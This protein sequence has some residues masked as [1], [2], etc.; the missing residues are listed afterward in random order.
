MVRPFTV[1]ITL[2]WLNILLPLNPL[3]ASSLLT[4]FEEALTGDFDADGLQDRLEIGGE[5]ELVL[6]RGTRDGEFLPGIRRRFF[7]TI[8]A[9]AVGEFDRR[10]GLAD[11]VVGLESPPSLVLLQSG[12]GAWTTSGETVALGEV[13][14]HLALGGFD[15]LGPRD[16]AVAS[17]NTLVL[18]HGVDPTVGQ[19]KRI[20][21]ETEVDYAITH[22]SNGR[23]SGGS[24]R[25]LAVK[26]PGALFHLNLEDRSIAEAWATKTGVEQRTTAEMGAPTFV[27]DSAADVGDLTPGDGLCE[28]S[29]GGPCTLRA[30]V[31]EADTT[32]ATLD[33]IGF[34]IGGAPI[35][36]GSKLHVMTPVII[37]GFTEP[38]VTLL[39]P[40][41][42]P[43]CELKFF[44]GSSGLKGVALLV[45]CVEMIG[46]GNTFVGNKVGVDHTF[47][48]IDGSSVTFKGADNVIGGA[49]EAERNI[50]V[51]AH[52][53]VGTGA[54]GTAV[55][56]NVVKGNFFGV[57]P[58]GLTRIGDSSCLFMSGPDNT[59]G[60]AILGEGN[61]FAGPLA[62]FGCSATIFLHGLASTGNLI[63]GNALG[64]GIDGSSVLGGEVTGILGEFDARA[65][66]IGGSG[67]GSGNRIAGLAGTESHGI[68]LAGTGTGNHVKGN[69]IGTDL[70]GTFDLGVTG[71]G[72]F[73]EEVFSSMIG[74]TETGAGN[75]I[76]GNAGNG[77]HVKA[78]SLDPSLHSILGN[79][80]GVNL[81]GTIALANTGY[82]IYLE[83]ADEIT[84][85]GT[86]SGSG[87]LI[88]G[89]S[90][91]GIYLDT[92]KDELIQGN[93]IGTNADE[94]GLIPN[95][96]WGIEVESGRFNTIGGTDPGAG[97]TIAG[98]TLG[99]IG[100]WNI[101]AFAW[102]I[103]MSANSIY[104]NG[105]LA[106]DLDIDGVTANDPGDGDSVGANH[107][108]NFPDL[109]SVV[110]GATPT[111]SG[112]LSSIAS[113]SFEVQFFASSV[114][115][116]S[117]YGEGERYLG[118]ATVVTESD[119]LGTFDT[120][121]TESIA[122]G[123]FI[124]ATATDG[125]K[126]TSELSACAETVDA[127]AIFSDGFESGDVS[128]WSD[129]SN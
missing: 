95:G 125:E 78:H 81:G 10:D 49:T 112:T 19:E 77:I 88:S 98:N 5:Q 116:S 67:P 46:D 108:Q 92:V 26:S 20:M 56:H 110:P 85:G 48:D 100:V 22:L 25:L 11:I 120:V 27:V 38:G 97:N 84:I 36:L 117:G 114:C 33:T 40:S 76:S 15:G 74:G 101:G 123:E 61:L 60:G 45:P 89:N 4:N 106:I 107:G 14:R 50:F 93:F 52:L 43:F 80:I 6:Y 12:E 129:S 59:V 83:D 24:S 57:L 79:R 39:S 47:T 17:E 65:N 53:T 94:T 111:V 105:G 103:E 121:L 37:D 58:D 41:H 18:I 71:H 70:S 104:A 16:V 66:T 72:I 113:S 63:L 68:H 34:A 119:G 1:M 118:S 75:L 32:P 30:A 96:G 69:L 115:D 35:F 91:A 2:L 55:H 109:T 128:A 86:S 51:D 126:N 54:E 122:T 102:E 87:N 64:V 29:V 62:P 28:I 13:P 99:G 42:F 8:S 3:E 44:A 21:E 9:L 7:S 82:G 90:I 124:T 127:S 31:T 23:R 73:V